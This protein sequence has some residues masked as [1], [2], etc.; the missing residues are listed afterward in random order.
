MEVGSASCHQL[1]RAVRKS[2]AISCPTSSR[3]SRRGH[4]VRTERQIR[5]KRLKHTGPDLELG[6]IW[7]ADSMDLI[8]K[9]RTVIF[10]DVTTGLGPIQKF[11]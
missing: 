6:L 5:S 3:T 7:S 4:A 10:L 8:V 9:F 1:V 11:E 2:A